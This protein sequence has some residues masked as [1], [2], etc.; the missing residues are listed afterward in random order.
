[1]TAQYGRCQRASECNPLHFGQ[2]FQRH[3][4]CEL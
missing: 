2:R 1:L 3:S 4:L